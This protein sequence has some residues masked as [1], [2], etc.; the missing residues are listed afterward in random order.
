MRRSRSFFLFSFYSIIA[1][2][3][4]ASTSCATTT[5]T[6][7]SIP[8]TWIAT[9]DT[10]GKLEASGLAWYKGCDKESILIILSQYPKTSKPTQEKPWVTFQE[11][12][13]SKQTPQD[14]RFYIHYVTEGKLKKQRENL[15]IKHL[16]HEK[17]YLNFSLLMS[18]IHQK[19]NEKILEHLSKNFEGFEAITF[20]CNQVFLTVELGITLENGNKI[21]KGYLIQGTMDWKKKEIFLHNISP[22]PIEPQGKKTKNRAEE[23]ILYMENK[24]YTF[25]EGDKEK[26]QNIASSD[27]HANVFDGVTISEQEKP[28]YSYKHRV[29]DATYAIGNSF[30][31]IDIPSYSKPNNF[32]HLALVKYCFNNEKVF[33]PVEGSKVKFF[34]RN[35]NK[36]SRKEINN[37]EGLALYTPS[38]ETG[39]FL[40]ISDGNGYT[41]F[42]KPTK[43]LFVPGP[44]P[45]INCPKP[46]T[47]K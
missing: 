31:M 13:K 47:P 19:G 38:N 5:E 17:L 32:E 1:L 6:S 45:S 35:D 2:L 33:E 18:V 26:G 3:I 37:W 12:F 29:T 30:W 36:E 9:L 43:L 46:D 39:G 40:V 8:G 7:Q 42:F 14:N 15:K 41:T 16:K 4:T 21:A 11:Y 23:T 44:K 22:K 24:V 20:N 34:E 28:K 25:Y 27:F 10:D